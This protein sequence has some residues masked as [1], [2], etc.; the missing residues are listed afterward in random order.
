[1]ARLPFDQID[2]LVVG[3]LGKNY[4]GTGLDPN[5]IG[6]QRVETMPDLP[7]PVVTRL[8]VLDL[9]AETRGN[10][11]GIGLADLTTERLVRAHR[12]E[13]MRVNSL[14]SN[15]LTRARVP[16]GAADRP[17]RDRRLPRHLLADR[18]RRGPDGPDPQ[19]P[20]AD[21]PSGSPGRWPAR[22]RPT[23]ASAFETDFP[24]IPFDA[25]GHLD[26]ESLF[27][28]SVRGRRRRVDRRHARSR[29]QMRSWRSPGSIDHDHRCRMPI[30]AVVFDLDGLMFD[31][32]A[33][34]FRVAA[35]MLTA[36]GKRFTP[37]IMRA[38]I[39]RRA[40]EAGQAFK[41]LAGLDE[42]V[43]DLMAEARARFFA[44]MD[45]AVHPTPGL[46]VLL[47]HLERA[48]PAPGGGDLVAPGVRRA[49]PADRHRL[50]DRF[51]FVLASEDVTRGKP[52]P[53]I[54]RDGGRA[55]RRA[56]ALGPG[57]RGQRGGPGVGPG[58]GHVRRRRAA[59]AQPGRGPARR[60]PDRPATR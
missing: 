4:S 2:V 49:A 3:E 46:F 53:E 33:L 34:F 35:E 17:R 10:A 47:D 20:G 57:A 7:R 36:R 12:P 28:E 21:R 38:M 22:S 51:A 42:P 9:S 6:R 23:R 48:R 30:R 15:F 1:M 37:E 44:E 55:V 54:Y 43:E 50:R 31:T 27:P 14:T 52:D 11:L 16:L 56:A 8:A 24:P 59:R 26:Q 19:H 32:E 40:V 13:P 5:V 45:T 25:D 60:R 29:L 41:T 18:P 58:G 39:G